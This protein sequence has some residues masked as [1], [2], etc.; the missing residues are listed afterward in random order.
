MIR[1]VY[2][3]YAMYSPSGLERV[4]T[5]K[6]NWLAATGRYEVSIVT[7]RQRGLPFAFETDSRIATYDLS[8][9]YYSALG[10]IVFTNR[11][12]S[13]MRKLRPDIVVSTCGPRLGGLAHLGCP[14]KKIA[15]FH[16]SRFSMFTSDCRKGVAQAFQKSVG[17]FE[18]FV[19]LTKDDALDWAPYSKNIRQIYNPCVVSGQADLSARRVSLVGR[20][21]AQKNVADAISAWKTVSLK[22]PDWIL[23]VYG[24][25]KLRPELERQIAE[26]GLEG[27]VILHGSVGEIHGR[28]CNSSV[29]VMSSLYEGFPLSLLEG[30]ALG[31][32]LV[33]YDCKCGPSEI[34]TDS[35][36]GYLVPPGDV[37][38]LA[39]RLCR[40]IADSGLRRKMGEASLIV[41]EHF[42]IEPIMAQW[43]KLFTEL[44]ENH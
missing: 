1:L 19:V 18:R 14:G 41:A 28:M 25:G 15:E 34:I 16:F 31:M 22:Y 6:A 27:K 33:S 5:Q 12:A 2:V 42:R 7:S 10:K 32:P 11:L 30:A 3:I 36:N 20:L 17:A 23:D 4:V 26:A 40:L 38:A 29:L 24:E 39:D 37:V 43:D 21:V 8:A 9:N 13:L 44:A 35:V